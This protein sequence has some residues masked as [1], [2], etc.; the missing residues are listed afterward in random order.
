MSEDEKN[1]F[2]R[3]AFTMTTKRLRK[4]CAQRYSCV[5]KTWSIPGYGRD[6]SLQFDSS[7]YPWMTIKLGGPLPVRDGAP[8][9]PGI[10]LG[11]H[12][13][14]HIYRTVYASVF[15]EYNGVVNP[16]VSTQ[17]SL[18]DRRDDVKHFIL[19]A[20]DYLIGSYPVPYGFSLSQLSNG[21]DNIVRP[22]S[23]VHYL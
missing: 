6:L 9:R 3:F 4:Y 12:C 22:L 15:T 16:D 7:P 19:N 8:E 1:Q 17:M 23:E 21:I 14:D 11:F 20:E 18:V 2:A 10:Y 5:L 13:T